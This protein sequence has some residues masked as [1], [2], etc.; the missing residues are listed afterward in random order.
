MKFPLKTAIAATCLLGAT[1][2]VA[3]ITLTP[4]NGQLK[5]HVN[6]DSGTNVD[7][8][9]KYG[10][11]GTAPN[12]V[13][14][15]ADTAINITGGGFALINDVTGAEDFYQLIVNPDE[16]FSQIDFSL[17]FNAHDAYFTLEYDLV[18]DAL[19]YIL[20]DTFYQNQGLFDYLLDGSVD[21]VLFDSIRITSV[22]G[23][24]A[25]SPVTI[26]FEKQ[27]SLTLAGDAAVPE[28]ATWA[29][30]LIGFG[31]VGYTM[32]RRRRTIMPQVA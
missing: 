3:A 19:G 8:S 5:T 32:R 17:Q 28:P 16:D 18:G 29:M 13:T 9:I 24:L 14:F 11:T 26:D 15:D 30:M 31:A 2:A 23:A 1:P 25:S 12:N 4:N 6:A 10:T 22:A 7:Q 21:G 20:L 27:N